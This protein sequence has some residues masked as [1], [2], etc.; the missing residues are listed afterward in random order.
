VQAEQCLASSID[1]CGKSNLYVALEEKYHA[2]PEKLYVKAVKLCNEENI[3]VEGYKESYICSKGCKPKAGSKP[4]V[5][6][7]PLPE[8]CSTLLLYR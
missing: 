8:V 7:T 2:L 6:L 1:A 5:L 3:R 4:S